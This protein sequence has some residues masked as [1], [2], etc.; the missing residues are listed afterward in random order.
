MEKK[1]DLNKLDKDYIK[2]LMEYSDQKFPYKKAKADPGLTDET[3]RRVIS[4]LSDALEKSGRRRISDEDAEELK[5][6]DEVFDKERLKQEMSHSKASKEEISKIDKMG[7]P[8][9]DQKQFMLEDN[10]STR[11]YTP[12]PAKPPISTNIP[13][14]LLIGTYSPS[15]DVAPPT[16]I[17]QNDLDELQKLREAVLK[18]EAEIRAKTQDQGNV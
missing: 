7:M 4:E 14:S 10:G 3:G 8:P 5:Y 12:E 6:I 18:K 16:Q 9:E 17:S 15:K 2:R 11:P 13:P 1:P